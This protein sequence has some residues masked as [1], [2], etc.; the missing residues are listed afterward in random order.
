MQLVDYLNILK[1]RR[2]VILLTLFIALAIIAIGITQIPEKYTATS[3]MRILTTKAGGQDYIEY[4][5]DYADRL[6]GTYAEIAQSEPVLTQLAEYVSPL[7]TITVESIAATELITISVEDIDPEAA[8]FAAN[9]LGEL[10]ILQSREV[11]GSDTN[12]LFAEEASLPD[13]PSSTSPYVVIGLGVVLSLV[14]G[15]G[16]AFVFENLDTR[17]YT[18]NEMQLVSN[19][20]LIGNIG[21]GNPDNFLLINDHYLTEAFRRL[22]TNVFSPK[23]HQ[24]YKTFL[25]TSPVPQDGRSTITANLAI[26]AAQS[27]RKV[28]IIDADMRN[29]VQHKIFKAENEVGLNDILTAGASIKSA[30]QSTNFPNLDIIPSGAPPL[31]SEALDSREMEN[32]LQ[33]LG[34]MY[35]AVI[36]DAHSSFSVTDPAVIA[37]KVD[38]VI[39]VLRSGWDRREVLMATLNHLELVSANVTGII[40]NQTELGTRKGL[41][42]R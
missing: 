25:I 41:F 28:L 38:S 27:D 3:T 24:D 19:L 11:Y 34:E 20:P 31:N 1:R 29:P 7:P 26:I 33:K 40:A 32:V 13:E 4:D 6:I 16:L 37:P 5:I 21:N 2:G 36:V 42:N 35:D 14:V 12:I 30:I 8:Q 18:P 17:I 9:K 39:L 23:A 22:R 15:V 10:L